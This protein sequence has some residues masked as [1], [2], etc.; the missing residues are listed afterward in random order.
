MTTRGDPSVQ[1]MSSPGGLYSEA[2]L[3]LLSTRVGAGG[4]RLSCFAAKCSLIHPAHL[5]ESNLISLEE[6]LATCQLGALKEAPTEPL[7]GDPTPQA[8]PE[9]RTEDFTLGEVHRLVP[10]GLTHPGSA[11][12][13]PC[14]PAGPVRKLRLQGIRQGVPGHG[15]D[16][17]S[18]HRLGRQGTS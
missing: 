5:L 10:T 18:L 9:R 13:R 11:P 2:F 8:N 4:C 16:V 14:N 6:P 1:K 3:E 7:P 12:W 15:H 17:G